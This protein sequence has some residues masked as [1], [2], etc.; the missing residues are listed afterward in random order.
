MIKLAI[1]DDLTNQY[2]LFQPLMG[3]NIAVFIQQST[4]NISSRGLVRRN[5]SP[6]QQLGQFRVTNV[7]FYEW[8]ARSQTCLKTTRINY[9][10]NHRRA[11]YLRFA[12]LVCHCQFGRGL[13]G[14]SC[15]LLGPKQLAVLNSA[16]P[17]GR[18][19]HDNG[20]EISNSKLKISLGHACKAKKYKY[21]NNNN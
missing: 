6:L 15:A 3:S 5:L 7:I 19:W 17:G 11:Q 8:R 12:A 2:G 13:F 9:W 4:S 10:T 21:K 20:N 1:A 14:D 16:E 18:Q